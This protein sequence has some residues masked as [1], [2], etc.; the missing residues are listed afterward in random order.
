MKTRFDIFPLRVALLGAAL[1]APAVVPAAA[2]STNA[3]VAAATTTNVVPEIPRSVFLASSPTQ[4]LR[5]PF[6]P[7][8]ARVPV[9]AV[10]TR[11][12]APANVAVDLTLKAIFG[13]PARPFATINSATFG[14]GEERDVVTPTGRVRLRCVEIR[15]KDETVIVEVGGDRRELRF[16]RRK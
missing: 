5:D 16:P 13:T 14:I 7:S 12:N 6:F 1:L 8:T 15:T 11:T 10:A 2:P 9:A 3:P 4:E